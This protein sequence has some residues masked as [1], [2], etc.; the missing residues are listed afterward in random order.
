MG[1]VY[2]AVQVRLERPVA[3]KV[4]APELAGDAGF[5]ERFER[6]SRLTAAVEHPNV[7]PVYEAGELES[8]E[9]FLMM[10]WVEGGDLRRLLDLELRLAPA[11]AIELL[12]PVASAL[13][14]AH[15]RGLVHRD[16]K[17]A[18]ILIEDVSG[19][20]YLSDFG[21]ARD[22]ADVRT[23]T[24]GF[25][26]TMAY[27]APER[28]E[29]DPG[30]PRA[31]IY[32]LGCVLFEALTGRRPFSR[33]SEAATMRAHLS[34]PIPSVRALDAS[35]PDALDEIVHV[36]LAKDPAAR[37][38][39]AGEMAAALDAAL[40]G[41]SVARS[42]DAT[43]GLPADPTVVRAPIDA[44]PARRAGIRRWAAPAV[45]GLAAAGLV[46][47]VGSLSGGGHSGETA[48]F[49]AAVARACRLGA[50]D[51]ALLPGRTRAL[52]AS[53]SSAT[54]WTQSRGYV[55]AFGTQAESDLAAVDV[56][57]A[58]ASPAVAADR[59]LVGQASGVLRSTIAGY[60]VYLHEVAGA[61]T[62]AGLAG[63][64]K[65]FQPPSQ[66][67]LRVAMARL[68]GR[69]CLAPA[70][71][72]APVSLFSPA[73]ERSIAAP[74]SHPA[75]SRGGS[76]AAIPRSAGSSGSSS[77]GSGP[78]STQSPSSS[79]SSPAVPVGPAAPVQSAP[80][81]APSPIVGSSGS[82]SGGSGVGHGGG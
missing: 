66:L 34:D 80:A 42:G 12:R 45:A 63:V 68:S 48:A 7:I 43:V 74:A 51:A 1:V 6:E 26:G 73:V 5:A 81:A 39:D 30:S 82:S 41:R 79:S 72:V 3:L 71:P 77:A 15:A 9:L 17:P 19:H 29:G 32:S 75:A 36:A 61:T 46:T 59:V 27:A 53:L 24:G 49:R 4:L 13:H 33:D 57:L 25:L 40:A 11:R 20:V 31:D 22:L 78:I 62:P 8:G 14:A 50:S 35:V 64:V 28:F 18:N 56:A 52:N 58:E 23:G 60:R 21:I 54:A 70:P 37:F 47:A 69:D 65:G 76:P 16:V 10:R 44:P 38:G 2:R 55:Y 67:P